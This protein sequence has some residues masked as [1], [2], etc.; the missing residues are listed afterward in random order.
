MHKLFVVWLITQSELG[1]DQ[2]KT[3]NVFM[4]FFSGSTPSNSP[5]SSDLEEEPAAIIDL[6]RF[7]KTRKTLSTRA[8]TLYFDYI[9]RNAS[10]FMNLNVID[11]FLFRRYI[12]R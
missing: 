3:N 2:A 12:P 1:K 6:P 9:L 7:R 10:M 5:A 8:G 4:Q 11:F